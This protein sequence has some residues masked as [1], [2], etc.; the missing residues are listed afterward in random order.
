MIF[1]G[2]T[3]FSRAQFKADSLYSADLLKEDLAQLRQA[4]TEIHPDPYVYST[5]EDVDAAWENA[6]QAVL[7]GMTGADFQ[8]LVARTLRVFRDSHTSLSFSGAVGAYRANNGLALNFAV[9]SA[10]KEI[11]VSHD[12]LD[13]LPEGTVLER[14]NGVSVKK[15]HNDVSAYS[16]YEGNSI[17][18]FKRI[19]DALFPSFIGLE[20]EVKEDNILIV[21][22]PGEA[23]SQEI[24]YPGYNAKQQKKLLKSIDPEIYKL[25]VLEEESIA[26]VKIGSFAYGSQGKYDRFLKKSFKTIEKAGIEHVAIDLRNNTGGNSGRM[27]RLLSYLNV[28]D[29]RVPDNLIARQSEASVER[30]DNTFSKWNRFLLRTF[31]KKNEDAV[32]YTYLA[33]QPIGSLD[34]I[35]FNDP[36]LSPK[37]HHKG[38]TYLFMNGLSGSASANFAGNFKK[39]QLG[40]ILG[41][42]CLGPESGTWGNPVKYKLVNTGVPV[43]IASIRFNNDRSFEYDPKPVAADIPVKATRESIASET[44]LYLEELKILVK[45]R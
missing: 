12:R 32:N 19:S 35:Y 15:L 20:T 7:E 6:E 3:L 17:T 21:R 28:E 13:I 41:E 4:I 26:V 8:K 31:A 43:L 27:E 22:L 44:D 37:F 30:Y 9:W 45:T 42:T 23:R 16:I 39:K 14:F 36:E 10:D 1:M 34:T 24:H 33:D 25:T 29:V 5:I 38:P 40:D 18:G 2:A 11:V